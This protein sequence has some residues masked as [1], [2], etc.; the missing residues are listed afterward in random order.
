MRSFKPSPIR[1]LLFA[2][3]LSA[4]VDNMIFVIAWAII[5]RDQYPG[6]YL[7]LVQSMFFGVYIILS[8]W[9]GRLADKEPK[10]KVLIIGNMLKT[11]G[12]IL[13]A[14]HVDPAVSYAVVGVGA[15]V[16]SPAKYG[17]LPFLVRGEDEL[18]RANS[19]LESYTIVAILTGSVAGGYLSDI[20]I[21]LA[22]GVCVLLYAL[23]IAINT[24]IPQDPGNRSMAYRHALQEFFA[25]TS[26]LLKMPQ[27]H[28]SLWGTGSFWMTSSVLRLIIFAWLPVT[29]GIH[30]GT[31]ISM[32][33][34]VTGVGIALG[35]MITPFFISMKTYTRTAWFGLAMAMCVFAFT[36]INTMPFTILFLFLIGC[37]GG[38]FIVPMNACL[39]QVGHTT[40][41]AGKTIA[42]QNFVENSMSFAGVG[43]YTIATGAGVSVNVS[44]A[45]AGTVL[46]LFVTYLMLLARQKNVGCDC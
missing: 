13:L 44:V 31:K 24:Y 39:Q 18:L 15:V 11:L 19:S 4:F 37:F 23:S 25:D 9:V 27:S 36:L 1:A 8:P 17:I 2:Q 32:I 46:L 38:I 20:S 22:L 21:V 35:A 45:V 3:F 16:Y 42:V 26:A 12:V 7:P 30:S 41:G 29:L 34:A 28:Y 10:A 6:Y 43:I 5:I 14:V 40:V 33:I